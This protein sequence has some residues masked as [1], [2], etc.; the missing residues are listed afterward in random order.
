VI[1]TVQKY[2]AKLLVVAMKHRVNMLNMKASFFDTGLFL[3]AK[4]L[5]ASDEVIYEH[6]TLK[7]DTLIHARKNIED[8][9]FFSSYLH[10]CC[11]ENNHMACEAGVFDLYHV[12]RDLFT[13]R[14]SIARCD[15]PLKQLM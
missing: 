7:L 14:E 11:F 10:L 12:D 5:F 1:F 15:Y 8:R 3:M 4:L 9:S 13:V 2:A 6:R